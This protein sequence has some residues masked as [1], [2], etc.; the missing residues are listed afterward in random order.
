[1]AKFMKVDLCLY[2][3]I[4]K[5]V[6]SIKIYIFNNKKPFTLIKKNL[7]NQRKIVF[8]C[9]NIVETQKMHLNTVFL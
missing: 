8:E 7:F 1:M 9:K 5:K 4:K 6:A 2:Y 3:S